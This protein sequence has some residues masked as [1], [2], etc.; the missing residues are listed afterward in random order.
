MSAIATSAPTA[1]SDQPSP[2]PTG[3]WQRPCGQSAVTASLGRGQPFLSH[4]SIQVRPFSEHLTNQP[5]KDVLDR[6]SG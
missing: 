4:A 5:T 1:I 3:V 6:T 2:T